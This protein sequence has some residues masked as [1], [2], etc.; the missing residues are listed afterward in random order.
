[1]DFRGV[2]VNNVLRLF[3]TWTGWQ[4]IPD[5]A[6]TGPVTIISPNQLSLEQA[7]EVLQA[8]LGVRGFAGQFEKRGNTTILKI[9]PLDIAV[10]SNPPFRDSEGGLSAEELR[11]QVVTQVIP[12][13]NVD[14]TTLARDLQ[15][16]ISKGASMVGSS[17]TNSLIV[18]DTAGNVVRIAS[19][20]KMLDTAGSINKIEVFA[21]KHADAT[22]MESIVNS[23][24]RQAGTAARAGAQP[25]Q[26]G[27]PGQPG[28]P[29][30]PGQGGGPSQRTSAVV[31][32][33]D[34]RS[35]SLLVV[36]S[37]TNMVRVREL[38]EKLDTTDAAALQ[39][40]IVKMKYSDAI[41][42]AD[43]INS[44]MSG[45]VPTR[46]GGGGGASF[47][48]RV[49]GG[50][51]GDSNRG[52]SVTSNDPFAKVVA[53]QRTN[54]LLITATEEKM[55]RIDTLIEQLDVQVPAEATTF[56][57]PLKKAQAGDIA[58]VLGQAFGTGL[59]ASTRLIVELLE[60]ALTIQTSPPASVLDVGTGTG[61]LA[62]CAVL[63]GCGKAT[64]IDIDPVAIG[65]ART[66]IA[67]NHLEGV[68]S[69]TNRNL[70]ELAGPYNLIMANIIH[71]TLVE[72]APK[73]STLLAPNGLLL[74]SGIL[75][76]GQ[77]ENI[78]ARYAAHGLGDVQ[79]RESG[80]WA[81]IS[82]RKR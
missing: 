50:G 35:N 80:E 68:I 38:I 51:G 78:A 40:K 67:A 23:I 76:G 13:S 24:F 69:A 28:G 37:E 56:V 12:V 36:A 75:R 72:M 39:T 59:H 30:Q 47:F 43:L 53:D 3:A 32:V 2:D 18:T 52:Q 70:D 33:A 9:V 79:S 10:K 44:V 41:Y 16:L 7:F 5:A 48:Q 74:L 63:L 61:I 31:A 1:M 21:L 4:I 73:L 55:K 57:I 15:S 6:L 82:L 58:A 65:A 64:G 22:T 27:Q 17:G 14:A 45:S 71:N 34:T 25:V 77:A 49:F 8:T 81:A 29:G 46:Q 66:N 42:V 60:E 62:I 20:V 19:L 11:N 54:S 26:P